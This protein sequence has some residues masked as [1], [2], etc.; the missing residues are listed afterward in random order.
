M[1]K[2]S[3]LICKVHLDYSGY[4]GGALKFTY[5]LLCS[6][7]TILSISFR[8]LNHS[9][10]I[11]NTFIFSSQLSSQFAVLSCYCAMPVLGVEYPIAFQ[12]LPAPME[13]KVYQNYAPLQ[14]Q[15]ISVETNYPSIRRKHKNHCIRAGYIFLS[16]MRFIRNTNLLTLKIYRKTSLDN[17]NLD[18]P[19]VKS[20]SLGLW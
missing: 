7:K 3:S 12:H 16:M 8:C 20:I 15:P 4:S 18:E 13:T 2:R 9:I 5:T 6:W 10:Y 17:A 11:L 19:F 1:S 14:R